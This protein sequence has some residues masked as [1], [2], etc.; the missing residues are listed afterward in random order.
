MQTLISADNHLLLWAF[1]ML[2]AAAAIFMEQN[3][4]LA[5]KVPGAVLALLIALVASNLGIIPT[6]APVFDAVWS[7]IVPLAIPLLLFQLDLHAL[8]KESGR[9]LFIFLISSLGTVIGTLISF[10]LLK[11]YIPELDKVAGMISA[12]YTGGGV[13]FAAMSAKLNPA[14]DVI[15]ATIVADNLMMAC[16]F[17]ILIG[18]SSAHW[19]RKVWGSPYQDKLE[20][21][22][23][24]PSVNK[25]AEYWKPKRSLCRA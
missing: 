18:I 1:V 17:F 9:M 14:K 10:A 16:Y 2:A 24:D 4:R 13:N 15:A 7:Y 8:F 23:H 5:G 22:Y 19:V 12:S 6:D 20:Q 21:E 11:D 3:S 25:A